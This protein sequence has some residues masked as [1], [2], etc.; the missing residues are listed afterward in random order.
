MTKKIVV[1]EDALHIDTVAVWCPG[2]EKLSVA[3][4]FA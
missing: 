3:M 2:G 1:K 4:S